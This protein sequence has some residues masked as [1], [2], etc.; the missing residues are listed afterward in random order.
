[1]VVF[2]TVFGQIMAT[3]SKLFIICRRNHWKTS[4]QNHPRLKLL[5]LSNSKEAKICAPRA[6]LS[7]NAYSLVTELKKDFVFT[8]MT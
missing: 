1:M 2:L 6:V 3:R 7:P 8:N 4:T 5:Y